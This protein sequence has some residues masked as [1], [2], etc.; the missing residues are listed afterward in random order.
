MTAQCDVLST[1]GKTPLVRLSK[2]GP[3]GSAEVWL[4]LEGVNPTGSYKDR[5]ALAILS[6]AMKRGDVRAGNRVVEYTGGSTGMA[7]ALV[8]AVLGLRFMAVSS[9][10]FSPSK[11]AGIRAFGA[12][13]VIEDSP[14]GSINPELT[15]RM[16]A[17]A[18]AL[19]QEP[20]S[21]YADQFGSPDGL[22]GYADMGR[23]IAATL[24]DGIDLVCMGVG[25]GTAFM[26][27]LQGLAAEGIHPAAVAL[28]PAQSPFL[29]TG[30]GGPHRVEG[31]GVGFKPPKLDMARISDIKAIDQDEAF[32]MCRRLACEEGIFGGGSTGLNVVAALQLAKQLGPGK[33]VVTVGCDSGLKYL[34]G[35]IFP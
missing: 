18:L 24:G 29:T 14:D 1:I 3:E 17:R 30:K 25:T 23:E 27:M 7:L 21:Y 11:L 12:E 6:S 31:I 16:K 22:G 20:G 2:I 35:P 9:N 19:A 5:L 4:K 26:G 15:Q 13:V 28:E 10:A 32:A 8:S 34:G 33:R